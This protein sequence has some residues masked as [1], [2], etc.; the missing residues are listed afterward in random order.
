MAQPKRTRGDFLARASWDISQESL[1]NILQ[2][3]KHS[4]NEISTSI[5]SSRHIKEEDF[6]KNSKISFAKEQSENQNYVMIE[7]LRG[8]VAMMHIQLGQSQ[9][10]NSFLKSELGGLENRFMEV[11]RE[12]EA[13]QKT[14]WLTIQTLEDLQAQLFVQTTENSRLRKEVDICMGLNFL[15]EKKVEE[16]V[17]KMENMNMLLADQIRANRELRK[18]MK[19]FSES[20]EQTEE[21]DLNKGNT[22]TE[23]VRREVEEIISSNMK[24]LQD[25][26]NS[27]PIKILN[28]QEKVT[29]HT[30]EV[31]NE[32]DQKENNPMYL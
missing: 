27:L 25:S 1:N 22:L 9:G 24:L 7:T 11:C 29:K 31:N 28:K 15:P 16:I 5:T 3:R 13:L 17:D 32:P 20:K 4:E 6:S 12:N 18:D 26:T 8:Q 23:E 14:N 21:D 10:Q 2:P 19:D 30:T